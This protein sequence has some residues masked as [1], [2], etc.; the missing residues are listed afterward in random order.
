MPFP[1][2]VAIN[3]PAQAVAAATDLRYPVLVKANIGGSGAGITRY[4]DAA[5]LEGAVGRAE[6]VR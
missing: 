6:G 5:A 4:E 3:N 1:R 2:A